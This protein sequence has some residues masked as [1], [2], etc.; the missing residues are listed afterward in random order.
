MELFK[1]AAQWS[2]RPADERFASLEEMHAATKAY[3]DTAGTAVRP[4]ADLRVET[5]N[6][7]VQLT[8][9]AGVYARLTHWAFGQVARL[10]GAPAEYLRELPATLAVQ[11][12]NYGLKERPSDGNQAQLLFHKNGDLLLRAI[13]SEMYTR[14]WNHEIVQRLLPLQEYGWKVPPARPAHPNQ[15]GARPATAADVSRLGSDSGLSI[16]PG[17]LIAPAGLYASDHDMFA[18]M[19][20]ENNRVEDGSVGGLGRGFFIENSEVGASAFKVTSFLYRFVCGNH[21]VWGAEK[22]RQISI[23]HV[24]SAD[25][26]AWRDLSVEIRKY[27][28]SSVGDLQVLVAKARKYQIAAT[29][30]EVLDKLFT[31]R[32]G[33][34]RMLEDAY[35]LAEQNVDVDGAPT[36]AWGFAQGL[37]R[38]SQTSEFADKRSLMDKAAG[39]VLDIVF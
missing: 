25:A 28:E 12:L 14:I 9:R 27:S 5:V 32:I 18:F 39:K 38:L 1:A 24:G 3:A 6:D 7:E 11:N 31:L 23:R 10:V 35:D 29:K 36:T 33:S 34:R 16:K 2:T 37:T 17:D 13:T 26:R 15:P 19:V 21:I 4:F 22:V 20:N 30:D 8:G